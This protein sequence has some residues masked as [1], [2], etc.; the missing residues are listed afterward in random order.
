[1]N[2]EL[3]FRADAGSGIGSG[4]VMRCIALAQACI[5]DGM[6]AQFFSRTGSDA[7]ANRVTQAGCTLSVP[8]EFE[9]AAEDALA[10]LELARAP[11]RRAAWVIVDGYQFDAKYLDALAGGNVRLAVVDDLAALERY[12]T[13][14]ILNQNIDAEQHSYRAKPGC[15]LLLGPAHAL[16][17][18]EF[19]AWDAWRRP[20]A[21]I[22]S[23]VLVTLGGSDAS[24]AGARV[25]TALAAFESRLEIRLLR[26]ATD[27]QAASLDVAAQVARSAGHDVS[28][29]LYSADMPSELAW[30]DV[31]IAGGGTTV[32]EL[33][34]MQTPALLLV[35]AG[36]QRAN[37]EGLARAGCA[38]NLGEWSRIRIPQMTE[39]I[40][41]VIRDRQQRDAMAQKGRRLVDGRGS[42]RTARA[43]RDLSE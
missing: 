18:P 42:Q 36:N 13:D 3:V 21:G 4:H 43:I 23:R 39:A 27:A 31:A 15:R 35:L 1:M 7:I 30:A 9:S 10:T 6:K 19:S 25:L 41:T 17:R 11:G 24:E 33:A 2:P 37:V 34:Y 38:V 14:I 32:W 5:A 16:L 29:R 8:P 22:A 26:G 12:P 40:A 20:Q 28:L